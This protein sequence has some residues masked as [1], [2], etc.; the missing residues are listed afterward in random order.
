MITLEDWSLPGDDPPPASGAPSSAGAHMQWLSSSAATTWHVH[1]RW[2]EAV[3]DADA[4]AEAEAEVEMETEKACAS[5]SRR[6]A[7]ASS[8]RAVSLDSIS[9]RRRS[10]SSLSASYTCSHGGC[11]Q[12]TQLHAL[13]FGALALEACRPE[14]DG[15]ASQLLMPSLPSAESTFDH[16][17]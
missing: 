3:A 14:A 1:A 6:S 15:D 13:S 16:K 5:A 17:F 9:V 12:P 4:G 2:A 7:A 8:M 10:T 11:A